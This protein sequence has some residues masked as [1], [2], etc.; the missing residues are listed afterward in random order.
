MEKQK[1]IIK[2]V[3]LSDLLGELSKLN[4]IGDPS[5]NNTLIYITDANS[6]PKIMEEIGRL[7]EESFRTMGAGTGKSQ[8]IDKYDLADIPFNQMFIWDPDNC[9]ITGAYR[10]MHMNKLVGESPTS[11]LFDL[12]HDFEEKIKDLTIELGRSFVNFDAKKARYALHNLWDGLGYLMHSYP[13]IKYFFGKMTF[14]PWVLE[15]KMDLL[16][17]FLEDHFPSDG[18]VSPKTPVVVKKK[19][20][21]DLRS[22]FSFNRKL[23]IRKFKEGNRKRLPPLV[24]AYMK[25]SS[26]MKFLGATVNARFGNVVEGAILIT[27]ADVDPKILE[28]H[29][30]PFKS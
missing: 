22:G 6:S 21:F 8:D 14:Y 28:T 5:S 15:E 7:R 20:F 17:E 12:H 29:M 18:S 4:P 2:P 1:K 25:L 23:L 10:Y 19:K 11:Y 3:S 30:R 24:D 26:T 16:L 27:I 13:D 9:E